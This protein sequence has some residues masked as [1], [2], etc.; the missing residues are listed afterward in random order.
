ML[1]A[2]TIINSS[3]VL[4]SKRG[5]VVTLTEG[6]TDLKKYNESLIPRNRLLKEHLYSKSHHVDY[7]IFHEGNVDESHQD[8]I[9]SGSPD[10]PL[11][12]VNISSVF[13]DFH[14]VNNPFCPPSFLSHLENTPAGYHSMCYFW[15][16][17]F[18]DY[19]VDYDWMLRIDSDCELKEDARPVVYG[20]PATVH[21]ASTSW[22]AL[23]KVKFDEISDHGEGMVVRGMKNLTI[24]FA[25]K[26]NLFNHVSSW[27]APYSN[28]MYLNLNWL[29]NNTVITAFTAEVVATGCIYGNRWGDLPLWGAAVLLADQPCVRMKIP[30][31]H[32]SHNSHVE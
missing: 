20:L 10:L 5:V 29:R 7:I 19:V 16:V 12:F 4:S 1:F 32:R 18:R 14:V 8:Y 13:Q 28:L 2:L 17:A 31:Y 23:D 15:F 30:Y 25:R 21:V 9:Q 22:I 27:K 24:T 11:I 3:G 26:H 6:F